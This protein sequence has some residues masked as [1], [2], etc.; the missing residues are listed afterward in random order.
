MIIYIKKKNIV[1]AIEGDDRKLTSYDDLDTT[2][3]G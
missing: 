1:V 3:K 2:K